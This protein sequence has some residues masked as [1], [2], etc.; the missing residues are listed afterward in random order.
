MQA[1]KFRGVRRSPQHGPQWLT[2]G[3]RPGSVP[4]DR[5]VTSSDMASAGQRPGSL[6]DDRVVTSSDTA[7]A[8]RR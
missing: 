7:S 2:P 3:Q 1:A 4:D 6:P 5:A 8:T